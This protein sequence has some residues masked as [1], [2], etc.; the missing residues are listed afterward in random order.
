MTVIVMA[1]MCVF[2]IMNEAAYFL[3]S[4]FKKATAVQSTGPI[5]DSAVGWLHF[6]S[7]QM[8]ECS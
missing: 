8:P 7:S 3:L 6:P 1:K 5:F 2:V 4:F